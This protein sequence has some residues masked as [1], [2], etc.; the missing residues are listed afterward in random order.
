MQPFDVVDDPPSSG[1]RHKEPCVLAQAVRCRVGRQVSQELSFSVTEPGAYAL[2]GE[3]GAGKTTLLSVLSGRVPIVD[4]MINVGGSSLI[5]AR[6]SGQV[7]SIDTSKRPAG[8]RRFSDWAQARCSVVGA[9][10]RSLRTAVDN[11]GVAPYFSARADEMSTG[12]R[13]RCLLAFAFASDAAVLCLD[14]PERG[15]DSDAREVLRRALKAAKSAGRVVLIATHDV[16]TSEATDG[17][18]AIDW[19]ARRW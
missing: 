4:G 19:M 6:A 11:W 7:L 16:A 14:E 1:W 5:D 9:T 13:A 2:R 10:P 3:N 17:V 18:I 12:M 15:L 8:R